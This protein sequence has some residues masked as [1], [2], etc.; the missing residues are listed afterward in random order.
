MNSPQNGL[1]P[2]LTYRYTY[3]LGFNLIICSKATCNENI[4]LSTD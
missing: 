4:F 1:Q 2:Y 3:A